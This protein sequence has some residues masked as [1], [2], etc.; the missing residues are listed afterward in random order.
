L[1]TAN[2]PLFFHW[3][4]KDGW[5]VIMFVSSAWEF[6]QMTRVTSRR[7]LSGKRKTGGRSITQERN[8]KHHCWTQSTTQFTW[9][10][11]PLR[12]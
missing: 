10:I 12:L 2:S 6:Q 5:C 7:L 8:L 4:C 1:L 3:W 9:R 11:C